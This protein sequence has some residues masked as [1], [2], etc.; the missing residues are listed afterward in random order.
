MF[1]KRFEA[2]GRFSERNSGKIIIFWIILILVLA[3][4]ASLLFHETSYDLTSSIVPP[5]AMATKSANLESQYFQN[6]STSGS[7][8]GTQSMVMVTTNTSI[9]STPQMGDMIS[10]QNS[11]KQYLIS[12]G[13]NV[14]FQSIVETE[15]E[16]LHGVAAAA[17]GFL[18]L[19]YPL[20]DHLAQSSYSINQ[21]INA[22]LSIII[23]IPAYYLGTLLKPN[24]PFTAYNVTI[25]F[26]DEISASNLIFK[27]I[28][29][30]YFNTFAA[31]FN[32]SFAQSSKVLND[33]N[34]SI[35]GASLNQSLNATLKGM[36]LQGGSIGSFA[37]LFYQAKVPIAVTFNVTGYPVNTDGH[38]YSRF[39]YNFTVPI[40]AQGISS[41][42][43][44][45]SALQNDLNVTP[46]ELAGDAFN[47]SQP[48][49][50]IALQ[51]ESDRVVS[52]GIINYFRGS[53]LIAINPESIHAFVS[54][55]NSTNN[56]NLTISQ[57]ML[58]YNFS[59]YPAVPQSYV[60][61]QFVGYDNSTV[62]TIIL[63]S[64]NLSLAQTNKVT[65]IYTNAFN[66]VDGVG[67]YLAGSSALSSQL[68]SESIS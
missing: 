6:N 10:A 26:I 32:E 34:S 66:G 48:A 4:F 31:F 52:N 56:I 19:A 38:L 53:P 61:H 33:I 57:L 29:I 39:A 1:E 60:L 21:S 3:P 46:I 18:A 49:D 42:S 12:Q 37:S 64:S 54:S 35:I 36:I 51:S 40:L 22:S 65:S 7:G 30:P 5:N 41:N 45:V 27:Q 24:S 17:S 50:S 59:S 55:V 44:I 68:G 62:I 11:V 43:T 63:V 47:L 16:T 28:G 58:D 23:G 15:N 20:L 2:V 9:N 67:A 8:N 25:E 14:S 13:I